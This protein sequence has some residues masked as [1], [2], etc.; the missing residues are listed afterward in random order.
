[1]TQMEQMITVF[2]LNINNL[3]L[4]LIGVN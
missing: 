4:I 3:N 2:L 1:M